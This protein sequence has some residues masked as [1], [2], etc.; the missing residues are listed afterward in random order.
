MTTVRLRI[1]L[2]TFTTLKLVNNENIIFHCINLAPCSN[3]RCFSRFQLVKYLYS[4][5]SHWIRT[6]K[7]LPH[8]FLSSKQSSTQSSKQ[9]ANS[10][11]NSQANIP[12]NV[13]IAQATILQILTVSSQPAT[14]SNSPSRNLNLEPIKPVDPE[15]YLR[16]LKP[17]EPAEIC[18]QLMLLQI[19]LFRN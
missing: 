4:H 9:P 17:V 14:S 2:T 10:P 1:L 19:S 5:V 7:H 12:T 15:K 8:S 18:F 13:P 6:W 3:P 11:A 16:N